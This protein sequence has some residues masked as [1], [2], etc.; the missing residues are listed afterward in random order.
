[1][2]DAVAHTEMEAAKLNGLVCFFHSSRLPSSFLKTRPTSSQSD[3]TLPASGCRF[4]TIETD[5]KTE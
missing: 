5:L 2:R 1:M 3:H 4:S